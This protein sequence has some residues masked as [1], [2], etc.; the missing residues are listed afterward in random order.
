M[1]TEARGSGPQGDP[2]TDDRGWEASL[3][4]GG[5]EMQSLVHTP[6]LTGPFFVF[7]GSRLK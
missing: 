7:H 6:K 3:G 2:G 1:G 5:W 4:P